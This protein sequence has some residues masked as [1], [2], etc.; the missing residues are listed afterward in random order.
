[1]KRS[2]HSLVFNIAYGIALVLIVAVFGGVAYMLATSDLT[3]KNGSLDAREVV[4]IAGGAIGILALLTGVFYFVIRID[5]RLTE[6]D[7]TYYLDEG[8]EPTNYGAPRA[9]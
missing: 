2:K 4:L 7:E 8:D 5:D 9:N 6:S 1:M 3:L